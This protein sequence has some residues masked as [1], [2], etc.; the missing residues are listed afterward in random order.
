[1][2]MTGLD[3]ERVTKA[4]AGFELGP[5]SLSLSEEVLAVLGPSGCG[6]TT[7]LS[8][9]AGVESPDSG[10]ISLS[11]RPLLGTSPEDRG[12]VLLFQDGALFPHMTA[13]EN[14]AYA[15]DTARQVVE[16]ADTLEIRDILAQRP[17]SLSGG[18]VQRV[19]LAR[20][21]AADPSVL[22]LDEPFTNLD[23]PIKRRLQDELRRL[24]SDLDIPIIYVTHDQRSASILGDRIAVMEG[25]QVH[26]LGTPTEV[27]EK[28]DSRFVARFTGNTN[29]FRG[30]VVDTP[31]TIDWAGTRLQTKE[32]V[33]ILNGE[34]VWFCIR[35]E[36]VR[37]LP[38]IQHT[39]DT[40]V[41][42]GRITDQ[43]F[44][45]DNYRLSVSLNRAGSEVE[46]T[47]PPADVD[48]FDFAPGDHAALA[49]DEV[50]VVEQ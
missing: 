47:V 39:N 14:I 48:R 18:Q 19:A 49:F 20:A 30:T 8:L 42:E 46:V 40:A 4:Y 10:R 33:D 12:T 1:M 34:D 37:V 38:T 31:R 45:G 7:L 41:I 13:R 17:D 11:G 5:L 2:G 29:I 50:H 26:Q 32:S 24:F 44:T 9:I 23:T 6:K 3:L 22:L 35:P 27:F 43:S 25:G 28:P 21:L 16:L 15:A 36:R